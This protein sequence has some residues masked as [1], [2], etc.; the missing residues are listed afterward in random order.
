MA[1]RAIGSDLSVYLPKWVA[2]HLREGREPSGAPFVEDAHGAVLFLDIAGFT[3]RTDKL[4]QRGARGSEELSNLL[5]DCCAPLTDIV[6]QHG[7]DI[8]AFAGDGFLVLWQNHDISFATHLAV[9]CAQALQREAENWPG[10]GDCFCC[11]E[12]DS[13]LKLLVI[14]TNLTQQKLLLFVSFG[15]GRQRAIQHVF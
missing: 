1:S 4:A 12:C 2:T 10:R 9:Q 11:C 15:R 6:S 3:E 14:S 8:I 13:D 7:G 5:E